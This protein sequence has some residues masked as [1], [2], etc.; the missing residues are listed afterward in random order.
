MNWFKSIF[1]RI[2]DYR[3]NPQPCVP[4]PDALSV[5]DGSDQQ[6]IE[7]K[8]GKNAAKVQ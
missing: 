4:S 7:N 1:A 2:K 8:L 6:L 3:A 5:E